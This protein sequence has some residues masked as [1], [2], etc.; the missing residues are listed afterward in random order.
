[1]LKTN[2]ATTV[3]TR[4][5]S[6]SAVALSDRK[7]GAAMII[8]IAMT[9]MLAFLGFFF[10]S[11]I[12][13][14]RN[15][16][17]WFAISANR[18]ISEGDYFDFALQ[19][20]LIGP[21]DEFPNSAL[22]G[23]V[24][25]IIPNMVGNFGPDLK[26]DDLHLFSGRGI[27]VTFQQDSEHLP[28][29]T[30]NVNDNWRFDYDGDGTPDG[31]VIN[32]SPG[33]NPVGPRNIP[34][35]P[36]Q[37]N[38]PNAIPAFEP[39]AGYTYPDINSMFLG[40]FSLV[41]TN[42]D[43]NTVNLVKVWI[44][45]FHRPQY[46][47]RHEV[48]DSLPLTDIYTDPT[49]ANR[50]LRPHREHRVQLKQYSSGSVTFKS[51]PRYVTSGGFDAYTGGGAPANPF[52]FP[53]FSAN[54]YRAGIW[55]HGVAGH[56]TITYDVDADGISE[57]GNEAILLDL[58]HRVEVMSDGTKR[59]P[60]FAITIMDADG[61]MN[62][63][64][65]GNLFGESTQLTHARTPA[66]GSGDDPF[67]DGHFVSN[68]NL[69]LSPAEVNLG[70]G[71]Y[72][73]LET[74]SSSPA[75]TLPTAG[76]GYEEMFSYSTAVGV[77]QVTQLD[78]ANMEL[79]RL[80][81]GFADGDNSTTDEIVWGRWGEANGFVGS[82]DEN[83]LD[84]AI[85]SDL[86]P[87]P[88]FPRASWGSPLFPLPGNT[89]VDDD[90]DYLVGGGK[91]QFAG[92][93]HRDPVFGP[94]GITVP[95]GV[96][97]IDEAAA[98]IGYLSG[99]N[100]SISFHTTDADY[101][102]ALNDTVHG[103]P[104][105][106]GRLRASQKPEAGSPLRLPSYSSRWE[107]QVLDSSYAYS[108]D[109]AGDVD[110]V[111]LMED[112]TGVRP[113]SDGET[114]DG[115]VTTYQLKQS[116]SRANL[117]L[118]DEPD[119]II[120][121]HSFRNQDHDTL[122]SVGEMQFLHF[123]EDD[124]D[125]TKASTPSRLDKL[126]RYNFEQVTGGYLTSTPDIDDDWW[127]RS[128]YTTDSWDRWE[129][130]FSPAIG[131]IVDPAD[132][133]YDTTRGWEFSPV[134][135]DNE[136]LAFPPEF[137]S[138]RRFDNE[139]PFR[140]ELRQWLTIELNRDEEFANF[141]LP[142]RRLNINRILDKDPEGRFRQRQLTPHPVFESADTD[143][144]EIFKLMYPGDST[145]TNDISVVK[146]YGNSTN[147]P[148]P[149]E[150]AF[151]SMEGD[152]FVQE[153]WARYDR[154]RLARDIYVMLYLLGAGDDAFNMAEDDP[155][156]G[157]YP[158]TVGVTDNEDID[159]D[160]NADGDGVNDQLQAMAQFAVNY[161]DGLDRDSVM[162]EFVFDVNLSDGWNIIGEKNTSTGELT[163]TDAA[164]VFGV[165]RQ[166]LTLSE[167]Y[168][169]QITRSEMTDS[170]KTPWNDAD[171]AP[172]QFLFVELRN[173]SP[174]KVQYRTDSWR[175]RRVVGTDDFVSGS[176]DPAIAFQRLS[177]IPLD[178]IAAGENFWIGAHDDQNYDGPAAILLDENDDGTIQANEVICPSREMDADFTSASA[179]KPLCHL[180][181]HHTDHET[182]R[183]L[184][185]NGTTIDP[186]EFLSGETTGKFEVVLE[187][188]LHMDG[189]GI[190]DDPVV[191]PW[192][193]VDYMLV[194]RDSHVV[195]PINAGAI[196]LSGFDGQL[197]IERPQPMHRYPRSD[198][199]SGG[200]PG[201][202]RNS[203]GGGPRRHSFGPQAPLAYNTLDPANTGTYTP[204]VAHN[205]NA[206]TVDSV[207][208][209]TLWQPHFD[210]DY[211]SVYELLSVPIVAPGMLSEMNGDTAEM[212]G[213]NTAF[214]KFAIPDPG[215]PSDTSD[216]NRWY[217][218]LEFLE[219]P[220]GMQAAIRDEMPSP[221]SPGKI[222][223]NTIRQPGVLAGL[224]DDDFH[225]D[226]FPT[227]AEVVSYND[228]QKMRYPYLQLLDPHEAERNW[229]QQFLISRDR[230]DP[231]TAIY[232]P[233]IPGSRPFRPLSYTPIGSLGAN[234]DKT[235]SIEHT[236]LRQLPYTIS[237]TAIMPENGNTD[238]LTGL[239]TGDPTDLDA[240]IRDIMTRRRLF[241]ARTDIDADFNGTAINAVDYHTRNRLLN[242]VANNATVRSNVFY[243]WIQVQ[244][245]EAA[246]DEFGN[247]QVGGQLTGTAH[248]SKRAFFVID[249]SKL[250]DAWDPRTQ[251]FD[252]RK[253]VLLRRNL[254]N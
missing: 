69:G 157:P 7:G 126:V 91:V 11:Y 23:R 231:Y 31:Q 147:N 50:V 21:S 186:Y 13:A 240:N 99:S 174:F 113:W 238:A 59:V 35:S 117:F 28:N 237:P 81:V 4:R 127:L 49:Y 87:T 26:P 68:S 95:S 189:A 104:D 203:T 252:W 82:G 217:R 207:E 191:N 118:A 162:T 39:D 86:P 187:R 103:A 60:I 112:W 64:T 89:G 58:D 125:D 245:H 101:A 84:N 212:S 66:G 40:H 210:R 25:S 140:H 38:H 138:V 218:L 180:D 223:L 78:M 97:P 32:F 171:T 96:H 135:N 193:P 201:S 5:S 190:Y 121:D 36:L 76:Y 142:Q 236:I 220:D 10:F 137:G 234:Y 83:R 206:P 248:K 29:D 249:R 200:V 170:N 254:T 100:A 6:H 1:M 20:V 158:V 253:F 85:A 228:D 122:F 9:G 145:N 205:S 250:E 132:T 54:G 230:R 247:V 111:D 116:N 130:A 129:F 51:V 152:K 222:N 198:G 12:S 225:L 57:N 15:S 159:L 148:I 42:P 123:S 44:P 155:S 88:P 53:D 195:D 151:A 46:L 181:I 219:V 156:T 141:P 239:W 107:R 62:L 216:D 108:G 233:G 208:T 226:G 199:A 133:A 197:S 92:S 183:T 17:S 149:A 71:F 202:R 55:T 98:G 134:N 175:L 163:E 235:Q 102:F 150:V 106:Y 154:Q 211:T 43:P 3:E 204:Y 192:V 209:F 115:T 168:Y 176:D 30:T 93:N 52:P 221:R 45:S 14:E 109:V 119:E 182:W 144:N 8:V 48:A 143:D 24:Y 124:W 79:A 136:R 229:Y 120:V 242:K 167:T 65:G 63:N 56:D 166:E 34:F 22:G 114:S 251:T 196:D 188:R 173:A 110:E 185:R 169:A 215:T 80:L 179:V 146:Q 77:N 41:D 72:R 19:Q 194:D 232:L 18:E 94:L 153:W 241:E 213:L 131:A 178:M 75:S 224:I 227:P 67:G 164:R 74:S 73:P 16:A 61:L 246:E 27:T 244:F 139:D 105:D 90:D 37:P 160:G 70:R 172:I 47:P 243:C 177:A 128:Q 161:V 2:L 165:E 214:T 33:A 184:T